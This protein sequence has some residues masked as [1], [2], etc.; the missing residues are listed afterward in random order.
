MNLQEKIIAQMYFKLKIY[1]KNGYEFQNFFTSIMSKYETNYM[2]IKTQGRLGDRKNDGYIPN[3]GI[4]F[5]VYS[6]KRL[7]QMKLFLKLKMI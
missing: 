6:Q 4:Y 1:E 2:P 3:K 7:M 5:Q